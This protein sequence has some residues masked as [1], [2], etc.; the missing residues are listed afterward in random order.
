MKRE[1][2]LECVADGSSIEEVKKNEAVCEKT[3]VCLRPPL[4]HTA[5][6]FLTSS[7]EEPSASHS[8][9]LSRFIYFLVV[10]V[11]HLSVLKLE[12]LVRSHRD[13]YKVEHF[14][15]FGKMNHLIIAVLELS[16]TAFAKTQMYRNVFISPRQ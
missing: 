8:T 3:R 15:H 14:V 6:F 16:T 1:S 9:T 7:M 11:S 13:F 12:Y 2:V 5:S 10:G 4:L